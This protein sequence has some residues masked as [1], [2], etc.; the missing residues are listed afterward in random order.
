MSQDQMSKN[1]NRLS[2]WPQSRLTRRQMIQG[3]GAFGLAVPSALAFLEACGQSTAATST[4]LSKDLK[5]SLTIWGWKASLD[6]LKLVDGD[7]SAAYPNISFQYVQRPPADTY[8]NIQLAIAAGAGAPDVSVVEDSHI[9][10]YVQ[11]GALADITDFVKPYVSDIV[12]YKWT[13]IKKSNRYFA[14]PWDPGPVAVF[15][16][17]D[18][19]QNAGVDPSSIK[20]WDDFYQAAKTIKDKTGVF[21]WQQAKAR[22]DGRLFETLLWQQGTGY[23]DAK[24]SVILD[25][26]PKVQ[27]TLEY[28]GRFWTDGLA[29][30]QEPWTDP[31]YKGQATGTTATVIDAVWMGTF[32]KS[33][34]APKASG[35]WGVFMLP[36][37]ESGGSQASNDGGSAL[38]I[39]DQSTQKEAAWAYVQYHLGREQ[40]QLEI[41][42]KTDIFP[43]LK[44]SFQDPFFQEP[45]PY[46]DDE[47]VR[48]LFADIAAKIPQAGI[49]STDYAEMSSLATPEIQKYALG[50]QSAQQALAN[51]ASLIRERTHRS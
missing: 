42:E 15:Y 36:A 32:F 2:R 39:F 11:L 21:M 19:F 26:D 16:R 30:D 17:R 8:R 14:M 12:S 49:Y 27:Q 20:T 7:F 38:A 10:Q 44:T 40:S 31:W 1:D 4:T 47:K 34:I 6:A 18:V 48:T 45:D 25:K 5:G 43:S 13:W 28:I 24:G 29:A 50:Q 33:F 9:S 46:F 23:I 41:Y 22:N 51:A 35:S 37:W 3:L